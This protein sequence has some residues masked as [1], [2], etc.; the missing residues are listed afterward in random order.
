MICKHRV[1]LTEMFADL[2]L[3]PK[4]YIDIILACFFLFSLF[5]MAIISANDFIIYFG[6][7]AEGFP[8]LINGF[9]L[10]V[11]ITFKVRKIKLK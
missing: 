9:R 10:R 8:H 1:W 7:D 6:N 2:T 11:L 5:I 3:C 4:A